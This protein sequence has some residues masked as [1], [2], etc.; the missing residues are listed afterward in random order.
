[1]NIFELPPEF[2]GDETRKTMG[3]YHIRK[4]GVLTGNNRVVLEE[5]EIDEIPNDYYDYGT[6][7][8]DAYETDDTDS[9]PPLVDENDMEIDDDYNETT[10]SEDEREYDRSASNVSPSLIEYISNNV[11][12][13]VTAVH[14][15]GENISSQPLTIS[16]RAGW[17]DPFT[18]GSW[19]YAVYINNNVDTHEE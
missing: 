4:N 10:Y 13:H 1:M 17:D 9:I 7:Y 16:H 18:N 14:G 12:T 3:T 15:N 8:E 5:G 19:S 2:A 6:D 11:D